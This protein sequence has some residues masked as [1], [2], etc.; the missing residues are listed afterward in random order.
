VADRDI[1]DDLV[2]RTLDD[3]CVRISET[4]GAI[5]DPENWANRAGRNGHLDVP[6]PAM[7]DDNPGPL[8]NPDNTSS[9]SAHSLSDRP[10]DRDAVPGRLG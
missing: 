8:P 9:G 4:A 10:H 2:S 3:K 7:P 6:D 5:P 1:F